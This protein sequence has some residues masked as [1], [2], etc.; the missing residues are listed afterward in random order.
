MWSPMLSAP[1]VRQRRPAVR[2][3]RDPRAS[4]RRA[5][6]RSRRSLPAC[7]DRSTSSTRSPRLARN[8]AKPN[9]AV[10]RKV[11]PQP[12][13]IV[14][15][16]WHRMNATGSRTYPDQRFTPLRT[17]R[18]G[19]IL[20][21]MVRIG[22]LVLVVALFTILAAATV[23]HGSPHHAAVPTANHPHSVHFVLGSNPSREWLCLRWK[24]CT[25]TPPASRALP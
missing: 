1:R 7:A 21:V 22:V 23:R 18:Q 13:G 5:P 2:A 8:R 11:G 16:R 19:R 14:G 9:H 15:N 10:P 24:P 20:D 4:V 3:G 25:S 12:D 17:A 6:R